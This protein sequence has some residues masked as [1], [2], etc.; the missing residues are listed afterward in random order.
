VKSSLGEFVI[1]PYRDK[2]EKGEER[3]KERG[4]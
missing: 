4:F 3:N 1:E 2:K